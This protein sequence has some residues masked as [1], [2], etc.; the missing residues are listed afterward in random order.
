M[1][2][3]KIL[4]AEDNALNLEI[5]VRIL[6][7]AGA[8]VITA[9]NGEEAVKAF[10]QS[11]IGSIDA[12]LMDVM[13]PVMDGI[14]ATKTIRSLSRADATQVPIIAMTANAFAEDIKGTHEAGM[15]THLSKPI[16][17]KTILSEMM[18][19]KKEDR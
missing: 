19:L 9:G 12:I 18:K 16:S 6:E 1:H 14:N 5:V 10:E 3:F 4:I 2:K 17:R 8:E 13:M 11:P 15:N 7:K